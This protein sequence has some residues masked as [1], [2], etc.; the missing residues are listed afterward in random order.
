MTRT[1]TYKTPAQQGMDK[2]EEKKAEEEREEEE[3]R[4]PSKSIT[5]GAQANLHWAGHVAE[6][7]DM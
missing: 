6:E 3:A 1:T 7:G 2:D 5:S 4:R